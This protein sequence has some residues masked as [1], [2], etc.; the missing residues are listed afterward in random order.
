LGGGAVGQRVRHLNH[1]WRA[2]LVERRGNEAEGR[3]DGGRT[4]ERTVRPEATR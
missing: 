3:H 4:L 2:R 1:R